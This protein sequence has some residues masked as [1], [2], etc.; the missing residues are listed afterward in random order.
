[1]NASS[2]KIIINAILSVSKDH[3]PAGDFLK[4]LE[5]IIADFQ[6]HITIDGSSELSA[7]PS[8]VGRRPSTTVGDGLW[9]YQ[10]AVSSNTD[11]GCWW[12]NCSS[13]LTINFIEKIFH[14]LP[15]RGMASHRSLMAITWGTLLRYLE[16]INRR[17]LTTLKMESEYVARCKDYHFSCV[18]SFFLD[19]LVWQR[20]PRYDFLNPSP[21]EYWSRTF[22]DE[23][24]VCMGIMSRDRALELGY[25]IPASPEPEPEPDPV[26]QSNESVRLLQDMIDSIAHGEKPELNEGEYLQ[27]S[28]SLKGFFQSSE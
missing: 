13:Q 14:P 7:T 15:S 20:A 16:F 27:L 26:Q 4:S 19:D 12:V 8:R 22:N 28:Q 23:E 18:S 2:H 21:A 3:F 9:R 11:R 6:D 5:M 17:W 24:A 1:M 25:L 10:G